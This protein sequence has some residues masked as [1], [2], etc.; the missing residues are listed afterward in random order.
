MK[1]T[2]KEDVQIG[3]KLI[4]SNEGIIASNQSANRDEDIFENADQF[5]INRR[6]PA[7]DALGF[8]FGD[9]RCIA[10]HLA[11]A[12]LIIVFASLYQKF[13]DLNVVIPLEEVN[14]TPLSGDVGIVDLPVT[15]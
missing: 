5:N 10:E 1:R 2:A 6:W 8:G 4:K 11:K 14:Y 15:L 12:E 7:E 3:G 9:H 13:P